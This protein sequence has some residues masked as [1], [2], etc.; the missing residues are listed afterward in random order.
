MY[1]EY[2]SRRIILDG[3][4]KKRTK[5][6]MTVGDRVFLISNELAI[7]IRR[8]NWLIG[9]TTFLLSLIYLYSMEKFDIPISEVEIGDG[10]YSEGLSYTFIF[11]S[12]V[13]IS[14][15]IIAISAIPKN[16]QDHIIK[17]LY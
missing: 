8:R 4:I 15:A 2:P 3:M 10:V 12:V 11:M 16:V 7:R 9:S 6:Q 1:E 14:A 17:E 5:N 13:I